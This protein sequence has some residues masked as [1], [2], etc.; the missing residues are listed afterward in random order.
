MGVRLE[1]AKKKII[2]GSASKEYQWSSGCLLRVR[3]KGEG[4]PFD[5]LGC[6]TEFIRQ[7][8]PQR[9]RPSWQ[10]CCRKQFMLRGT[11]CSGRGLRFQLLSSISQPLSH[12]VAPNK[13]RSWY[14]NATTELSLVDNVWNPDTRR[15]DCAISRWGVCP[16]ARR[17]FIT[18]STRKKVVLGSDSLKFGRSPHGPTKRPGSLLSCRISQRTS[19]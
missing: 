11:H 3:L 15:N 2:A 13:T 16:R 9:Q 10:H 12:H 6:D 4:R 14:C 18:T 7:E 17:R 19:R 5:S 1:D 8:K